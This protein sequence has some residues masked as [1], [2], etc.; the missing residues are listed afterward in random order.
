MLLRLPPRSAL[1]LLAGW[2]AFM[3]SL[4]CA[5][6]D[7]AAARPAHP[8]AAS[9]PPATQHQQALREIYKELI[10]IDT[11]EARGNCTQAAQA[12]AARLRA[13]GFP[14]EDVQV[15]VHPGR[16]TKGNLVARLRGTGARRPLLLLAHLDVVEALR[17]DWSEGIDPFTLTERDGYFYGRGTTD[18]KA[19]AAIFV[20][21]LIRYKKEGFTPSRDLIVAL[22]ADEEGG[23]HNGVAWLLAS[24]RDRIDAEFGL[25]E[26]GDGHHRQGK[27]LFNGVQAS[28]KIFQSFSL[29][30][31]NKGGHSSLPAKDNAIYRLAAALDRLARFDFPVSLNEVTRAYFQ[32]MSAIESGQAA[33]DMKALA[34]ASPDPAA[35][36]RL[37]SSP[38]YNALMRTTCVATQ[39]QGGHAENALPQTAKA[40][41]NCRIL[42]HEPLEEVQRT[43]VRVLADDQVR[44]EPVKQPKPSPPSPLRPE[45][46]KPIEDVT[47]ALW[48][49]VPVIPLMGTGATDS[50]YFRRA[51]IPMYGVSG[52]FSDTDDE[53]AHGK[54]E[55][56]GASALYEGQEFLYRLVKAL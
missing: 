6:G 28:E 14:A 15:L 37:S 5:S 12:M 47:R 8:P 44:V 30:V 7:H 56:L 10:E 55:R 54:D 26:G 22:T 50:L 46:M 43:L 3:V 27:R 33:V 48:P 52:L 13:A 34:A 21:N 20:A 29:E 1:P 2:L 49:G 39:L 32:R 40:I 45:V 38:Y 35:A 36:A 23:A 16:A 9:A 4:S 24:H 25:N 53:R 19:R 51:G 11:T 41:V 42:P 17:Q 18:D 31:R